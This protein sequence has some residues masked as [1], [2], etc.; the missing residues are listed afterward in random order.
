[1]AFCCLHEV[2]VVGFDEVL[3]PQWKLLAEFESLRE[4]CSAWFIAERR[5]GFGQPRIGRA[6]AGPPEWRFEYL[7][8]LH[9]L[10]FTQ[11]LHTLTEIAERGMA[12]EDGWKELALDSFTTSGENARLLRIEA[13]KRSTAPGSILFIA[14]SIL[15]GTRRSCFQVLQRG[16]DWDLPPNFANCPADHHVGVA[17]CGNA[18]NHGRNRSRFRV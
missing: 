1:M 12:F 18:A 13:A 9:I 15:M 5:V 16:V 10:A 8:C 11:Q 14:P 7:I 3:S 2:R 6:T 17:E 4:D